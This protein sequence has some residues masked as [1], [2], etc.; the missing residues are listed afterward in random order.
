MTLPEPIAFGFSLASIVLVPSRNGRGD[1][2]PY[3]PQRE[4][5]RD[6]DASRFAGGAEIADLP[7]SFAGQLPQI[8]VR[9]DSDRGAH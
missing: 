8:G 1:R 7:T 3:R 6:T 4:G 5:R 2:T 9:V